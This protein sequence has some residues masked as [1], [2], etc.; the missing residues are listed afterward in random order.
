M[1]FSKIFF[2]AA[3]AVATAA[4]TGGLEARGSE[5]KCAKHDG[6]WQTGWE[7]TEPSEQYICQTSG[8]L[9]GVLNSHQISR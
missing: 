9:V 3:A 7:G 6:K 1:Q 4:P 5:I 8:L 2:L